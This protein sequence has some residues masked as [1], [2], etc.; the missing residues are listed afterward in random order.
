MPQNNQL[1]GPPLTNRNTQELRL[2]FGFTHIDLKQPDAIAYVIEHKKLSTS[3][4]D[5]YLTS[6]DN[7][8][9][10]SELNLLSQL[11]D[12]LEIRIESVVQP[13]QWK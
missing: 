11:E 2:R 5:N 13:R 10:L 3:K 6:V 4:L 8:E 9:E 7:I 1:F 12:A